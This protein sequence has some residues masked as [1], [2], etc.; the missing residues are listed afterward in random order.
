MN[1]YPDKSEIDFWWYNLALI[2]NSTTEY[3][4]YTQ[5][6]KPCSHRK[7]RLLP[8]PCCD[9]R[10]RGVTQGRHNSAAIW[11]AVIQLALW[12]HWELSPHLWCAF[13]P[14]TLLSVPR[15]F[16]FFYSP[17]ILFLSIAL[18]EVIFF[19]PLSPLSPCALLFQASLKVCICILKNSHYCYLETS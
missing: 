11:Y 10:G 5:K 16:F 6:F 2:D 12:Q 8:Q 14:F 17:V 1:Y 7:K 19:K 15:F 13:L 3:I 9:S 4:I 18:K